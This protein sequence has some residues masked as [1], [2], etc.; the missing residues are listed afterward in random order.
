MSMHHATL[1]VNVLAACILPMEEEDALGLSEWCAAM[2]RLCVTGGTAGTVK[3]QREVIRGIICAV[4]EN[5][6]RF[7]GNSS[8][9]F[10]SWVNLEQ[11]RALSLG[12]EEGFSIVSWLSWRTSCVGEGDEA[13]DKAT[14]GYAATEALYTR[15]PVRVRAPRAP[16]APRETEDTGGRASGRASGRARRPQFP[17][18]LGDAAL[19][20]K[21]LKLAIPLVCAGKLS[22]NQT[23]RVV[24]HALDFLDVVYPHTKIG[25]LREDFGNESEVEEEEEEEEEEEDEE[26]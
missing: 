17:P 24:E 26:D 5:L 19:K 8:N 3:K 4:I 23:K 1:R 21:A 16:R 11:A 20:Y 9:L 25:R 14:V 22:A 12:D 18:K 13:D 10:H 7:E 15:K 6:P 2:A